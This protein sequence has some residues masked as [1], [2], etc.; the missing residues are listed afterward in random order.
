MEIFTC[1]GTRSTPLI[2]LDFNTGVLSLSGM[3][4]PEDATGFYK[5][6]IAAI[7]RYGKNLQPLTEV[8][9]NLSY[10]NTSS[11]KCILSVLNSLAQLHNHGTK[12]RVNWHYDPVDEDQYET[13]RDY[14]KI[15][16][17]EFKFI[18]IKEK[19]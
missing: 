14:E 18:E 15:T 16:E 10:F 4:I 5:D 8:S 2:H 9:F 6:L 7:A 19:D 3:S 17:L 12:V 11:S 1:E 13:A